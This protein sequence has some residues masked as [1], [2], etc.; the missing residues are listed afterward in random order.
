MPSRPSAVVVMA[1]MPRASCSSCASRLLSQVPSSSSRVLA[2]ARV[3]PLELEEL[4][5]IGRELR[6]A[7]NLA[8]K[9]QPGTVGHRAAWSRAED[10]TRLLGHLVGQLEALHPVIEAASERALASAAAKA[11]KANPARQPARMATVEA[12]N[13]RRSHERNRH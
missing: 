12:R 8:S 13:S 6:A 5:H 11:N 4:L 7:L 1:A 2:K 10:A 3:G 9:T